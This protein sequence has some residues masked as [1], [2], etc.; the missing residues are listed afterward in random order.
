MH[1]VLRS[2][3][4]SL[5]KQKSPTT[6]NKYQ[7]GKDILLG[8]SANSKISISRGICLSTAS[9]FSWQ[10]CKVVFTNPKGCSLLQNNSWEFSN[11]IKMIPFTGLTRK[12]SDRNGRCPIEW[13]FFFF[14][15]CLDPPV[16]PSTFGNRL[17]SEPILRKACNSTRLWA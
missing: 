10:F 16:F 9:S 15:S 17:L 6:L 5:K 14:P 8:G 3:M 4:D 2:T 12:T 7:G 11:E 13:T 1:F